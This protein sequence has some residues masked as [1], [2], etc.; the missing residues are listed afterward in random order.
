MIETQ[1]K[2]LKDI[3]E[4]INVKVEFWSNILFRME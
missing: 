1:N 2:I 4:L 3:H